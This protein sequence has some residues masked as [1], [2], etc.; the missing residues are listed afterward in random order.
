MLRRGLGGDAKAGEGGGSVD[1]YEINDQ[2]CKQASKLL[3]ENFVILYDLNFNSNKITPPGIPFRESLAGFPS[4]F[5][6]KSIFYLYLHINM[7]YILIHFNKWM[8]HV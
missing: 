5:G 7:D 1:L 2:P 6:G 4:S 3:K 8:Y